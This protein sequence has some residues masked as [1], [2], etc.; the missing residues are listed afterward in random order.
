M[1]VLTRAL[2]KAGVR[3]ILA[4]MLATTASAQD[5]F[6]D[7]PPPVDMP[8]LSADDLLRLEYA[9][10]P[11]VSPDGRHIAYVRTAMDALTDTR[12]GAIWVVDVD[13]AE[14]QP[15]VTEEGPVS[16]PRWSPDGDRLLYAAQGEHGATLRVRYLDSGASFT[17]AHFPAAP[18]TPVWS[19][20]GQHIAFA[21]FVADTPPHLTHAPPPPSGAS[22]A[23]PVE[24]IDQLPFRLDRLGYVKAGKTHIHIVPAEGGAVRALTQGPVN[25]TQPVWLDEDTLVAE[26]DAG[27]DI[28]AMPFESDL[29]AI[30]VLDGAITRLTARVGPD[31]APQV[32]PDGRRI[33]YLGYDDEIVAYQQTDLYVMNADGSDARLLTGDFDRTIMAARW[34]PDG[35]GLIIQYPDNGD[36]VLNSINLAGDTYELT[37]DVGGTVI[38]R[39]YASG[40]FHVGGGAAGLLRQRWAI[41]FTLASRDRPGE[42]AALVNGAGQRTLTQLNE[43][44][45]GH[46]ALARL[47]GISVPSPVDDAPIQAW[48]AIPPGVEADGTAPMILEIHGGPFA[49]YGP[50]F[51][52]EIQRF[53]AEGYV[54]VYANPRG[55]TGYGEAFAQ[56]INRAYPGHDHDDLMAVVDY[57]VAEGYVDPRRLF[58]TGGSGGGTLTA[59][60]VGKTDRFAAAASIKPVINW[61]TMALTA[62]WANFFKKYWMQASPW[63]DREHYWR[64]SPLSLVGNVTTPTLLM[65]GAEDWRTPAWEAEQFYTA[66][67]L[68]GVETA[69]VRAPGA[70]HFIAARPSQMIAKIDNILG[71]FARYDPGPDTSGGTVPNGVAPRSPGNADDAPAED[72]GADAAPTAPDTNAPDPALEDQTADE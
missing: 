38:G 40:T 48:I 67:R 64:L 42:V 59:W 54:T 43:D 12:R 22:W 62:D 2:G 45:L 32:S 69:L 8:R 29:V 33:A 56:E 49:M 17:L 1:G 44:A 66:L 36:V 9:S 37:R 25:H 6:N 20:N 15:L 47:Q 51:A 72:A 34:R 53:A 10:D 14:Q 23:K 57:L 7:A 24:V 50:T 21:M 13:T 4:G 68:Q 55:S 19:P 41:G 60:A 58:I 16:T 70:S 31:F 39:P 26:A 11:Q 71:W 30:D 18:Q 46:V 61:T 52:A 3:A 65:V 27:A 5:P 63:E 28:V 35:Q